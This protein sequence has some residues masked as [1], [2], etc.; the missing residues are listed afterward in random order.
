[1]SYTRVYSNF[2][3]ADVSSDPK[4]IERNRLTECVNMWRDYDSQ[5]GEA[6]E[7][8]PGFRAVAQQLGGGKSVHGMYHFRNR[9]G[10]DYIVV[11][12][13]TE[14]YS[15]KAKEL[16]ESP[17]VLNPRAP[18]LSGK[19][20]DQSS[21]G[22]L[23][24]NNLYILD[25]EHY[26]VV[27]GTTEGNAT[28]IT[29]KD[30]DAYIPTTY[31]DGKPYEQRNMLSEYAY[32]VFKNYEKND[33]SFFYYKYSDAEPETKYQYGTRTVKGLADGIGA[34]S[35]TLSISKPT[36]QISIVGGAFYQSDIITG[37][38]IIG[39]QKIEIGEYAFW[40][41]KNLKKVKI[42]ITEDSFSGSSK[43]IIGS[44][45]FLG[46][47]KLETI[48]IYIK[49]ETLIEGIDQ[50]AFPKGVSITYIEYE[51]EPY[52]P[53]EQIRY[54]ASC[55]IGE[56]ATAVEGVYDYSTN[57]SIDYDVFYENAVIGDN[58]IQKV[59]VVRVQETDFTDG[60]KIK[61]QLHPNHF[62][63]IENISS[64][65]DGN[66]DYRKTGLE[67]I[68]G[69]R[70]SAVFD[71][72]IF[73]TGNP[74][75]P[76]TVFYSNR[77]NTGANDPTYFGAYNYFNDGVGN[78][79][80]VELL[81]T[82]TML[83]VLKNNTVQ[84]GSIYY[85]QGAYNT[86]EFSKDLVPRIYPSVA[87]A[88]G[89]GSAGKVDG[90]VTCCNFLDDPVFLTQ[91][92][93]DCVGK[94][95]VN[96]ERTVMHRSS[97][98]DRL[99]KSE[100]L[101]DASMTEWKGYLII[102]VSG[103]AYMADSRRMFRHEDGSYQYEWFCL[104][105]LGVWSEYRQRFKYMRDWIITDANISL[106]D[107]YVSE[108]VKLSQTGAFNFKQI[109]AGDVNDVSPNATIYNIEVTR[110]DADPV[111]FYYS[112]E[113]DGLCYAV[114]NEDNEQLPA[115]DAEFCQGCRVLAVGDYLFFGTT[116][117][118]LCLVNTDKRDASTGRIG[119]D[120][121]THNNV[122]Y[123]SGCA[124]RL[125]D[126]DQKSLAK[127]TVCGTSVMMLKTLD[128]AKCTVNISINGRDWRKLKVVEASGSVFSF[129]DMDF[130]NFSFSENEVN[131]VKLPELTRNWVHKQYYVYSDGF[132]E[133]FG[134]YSISY[135]YNTKGK[136]RRL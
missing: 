126:C 37:V 101:A 12:A 14:L 69:C 43:L 123:T 113:D 27:S 34:T 132:K 134:L 61:L 15:F 122:A 94:E 110:P 36:Y 102:L 95:T 107:Y 106:K 116:N 90:G 111:T 8:F 9:S 80:N 11:H 18:I 124:T 1:M 62:S 42:K 67:A 84:D 50:W 3:G 81:A 100:S 130:S 97:N 10:D 88:T 89:I 4:A 78:T 75:L 79:P 49:R 52:I 35:I 68:N 133:P 85:H 16:S 70:K 120:W 105:D 60:I 22:F 48:E 128:G 135:I 125:D 5:Q 38:E 51:D 65:V 46:C 115:Q 41:C 129:D 13:G 121:Y 40:G 33:T 74:D 117:G 30:I 26:I 131:I 28:S 77:N 54:N 29:A 44:S 76:N 59:D 7:T 2:V 31:F 58:N 32:E 83:M 87:G 92:G 86:D 17:N 96:L 47:D 21:T 39:V 112:V 57:N 103:R 109:E 98:V 82:P 45:A 108:G 55:K 56:F 93:L 24:N 119:R 71:G 127:M 99:L 20:A 72:R 23:Y 118:T 6:V 91:R 73:L 66:T 114:I 53:I 136:I 104:D 64:F 63:T 25:G 19:L